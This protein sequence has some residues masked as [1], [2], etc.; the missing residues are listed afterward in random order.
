MI[1]FYAAL[2]SIIYIPQS[3]S[4]STRSL[5]VPHSA[6]TDRAASTQFSRDDSLQNNITLINTQ[7]L[8]TLQENELDWKTKG[9]MEMTK[10]Y[11]QS[12]MQTSGLTTATSSWKPEAKDTLFKIYR[13]PLVQHSQVFKDML[14]VPQPP[15]AEAVCNDALHTVRLTDSPEDLRHFLRALV[16]SKW[17]R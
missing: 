3:R 10:S 9:Q 6:I 17:I 12:R 7:C 11:G 2:I 13:G 5:R 1:I 16:P 14:S 8:A 15:P 4:R